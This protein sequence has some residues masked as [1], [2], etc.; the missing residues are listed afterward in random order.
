MKNNVKKLLDLGD[1]YAKESS[2]KDYAL[3]KFCLFSMGLIVGAQVPDRCKKTVIK[4][5][6]CIFLA[7]YIP[8]MAKLLRIA[9]DNE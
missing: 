2:W 4:T 1:R 5:S 9:T 6:V 8:L 7:T 3:V